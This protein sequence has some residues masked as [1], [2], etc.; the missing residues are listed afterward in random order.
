VSNQRKPGSQPVN[1]E[2]HQTPAFDFLLGNYGK[3]P[4][5]LM[6]L[7]VVMSF[8]DAKEF[9]VLA[10]E[11]PW[12]VGT[13]WEIEEL[14]QRDIDWKRVSKNIEPYLNQ[15]KI[16]FFNALTIALIP[17]KK[18]ALSTYELDYATPSFKNESQ[19]EKTQTVGPIK[20]GWWWVW[21]SISDTGAKTG[22]I[23]WN[24]DEVA[25]VAIDG[26]HRLAA[27][28]KSVDNNSST[29]N[30]SIPVLLV[31]PAKVFGCG[32]I[33][34]PQSILKTLRALFIDLN[35]NAK[36]PTRARQILLDDSDPI[37]IC[38]RELVASK[39]KSGFIELEEEIKRLPLTLVD[40][41]SEQAKFDRGPYLTTILG[42]EYWV[43][44]L[45]NAKVTLDPLDHDGFEAQIK[46]IRSR[47]ADTGLLSAT[48]QRLTDCNHE[49]LFHYMPEEIDEIRRIFSKNLGPAIIHLLTVLKPYADLIRARKVRR[50]DTKEYSAWYVDKQKFDKSDGDIHSES[51]LKRS[52]K[53]LSDSD[54]SMT[55][56]NAAEKTLDIEKIKQSNDVA[57]TVVFQKSYVYAFREILK[58]TAVDW[59]QGT[60]KEPFMLSRAKKFTD[61]INKLLLKWPEFLSIKSAKIPTSEGE[62]EFW[63]GSL[64]NAGGD[65][66]FSNAAAKRASSWLVIICLV[67][68]LSKEPYNFN[69][70]KIEKL[71]N[72]EDEH[73]LIVLIRDCLHQLEG[74][75]EGRSVAGTILELRGKRNP[76]SNLRSEVIRERLK[77]L[78][79]SLS[80]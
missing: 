13:E 12:G 20:V 66:D 69:S 68:Q 22:Q 27:I 37:S 33:E 25:A 61:A 79:I 57:F 65:I 45:L 47:F 74:D 78:I 29:A 4:N 10:S 6:Y 71:I 55:P 48:K 40:W 35:K 15:D 54:S 49:E 30:F 60:D 3:A 32:E 11:F 80:V 36:I 18:S 9:L 24:T 46:G 21:D 75:D 16:R 7:S 43:A 64:L 14:Y 58:I 50:L 34:S 19:F 52:A 73:P 31:I 28:K 26:Q 1:I 62:E 59:G 72:D 76:P 56:L 67:F 2:V 8:R 70:R 42:L 38:V 17:V 51:M 77:K 41:H 23:L 39:L 5:A 63:T 44:I 53:A